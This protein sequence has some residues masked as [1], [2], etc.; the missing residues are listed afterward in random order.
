V[1]GFKYAEVG[2]FTAWTCCVISA[3]LMRAQA[4]GSFHAL[5]V[6]VK[7]TN[8]AAATHDLFKRLNITFAPRA[9]FDKQISLLESGRPYFDLCFIDGDHSYNAVRADYGQLAPHCGTTMFHDI[10]DSSTMI[11]ANFSGGECF[12]SNLR[13]FIFLIFLGRVL[14]LF[15]PCGQCLYKCAQMIVC[16]SCDCA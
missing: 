11:H 6:D 8:I 12:L 15:L 9:K 7:A 4:V 1:E 13:S 14:S 5:A 3:Y 2:V 10:Q 16:P